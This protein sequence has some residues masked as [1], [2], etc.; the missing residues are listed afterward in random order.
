MNALHGFLRIFDP[1]S[2]L[3]I[4]TL[5]PATVSI[6][7]LVSSFLGTEFCQFFRRPRLRYRDWVFSH[8][9]RHACYWRFNLEVEATFH[10]WRRDQRCAQAAGHPGLFFVYFRSFQ[11]IN[12]IKTVNFSGI[13]TRIV[14]I[15][16][17]HAD[18]LTTTTPPA[19]EIFRL[20]SMP[21]WIAD[22]FIKLQNNR[23]SSWRIISKFV[24]QLIIAI[25]TVGMDTDKWV[26]TPMSFVCCFAFQNFKC[27]ILF[28]KALKIN[29]Y[30]GRC[31]RQFATPRHLK[32]DI[33]CTYLWNHL[34]Q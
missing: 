8:Y 19:M 20:L 28:R 11:T 21:K 22:V 33:L 6:L 1:A 5:L 18:H 26:A 15:E 17:E 13:R 7:W 14:R 34:L 10:S 30:R 25:L 12:R 24:W 9:T 29:H 4:L 32:I 3:S 31:H 2:N 27:H 23:D 16:G